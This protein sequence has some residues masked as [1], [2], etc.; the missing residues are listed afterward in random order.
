MNVSGHINFRSGS[1]CGFSYHLYILTRDTVFLQS[2]FKQ[3]ESRL[4]KTV[5]ITVLV[6]F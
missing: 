6:L 3:L 5:S 4:A 1:R 2:Q